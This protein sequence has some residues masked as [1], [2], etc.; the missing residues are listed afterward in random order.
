MREH[1]EKMQLYEEQNRVAIELLDT[2]ELGAVQ[3]FI[4]ASFESAAN[5]HRRKI[6]LP[7]CFAKQLGD[8]LA[9]YGIRLV[10]TTRFLAFTIPFKPDTNV[11]EV[12][13][14]LVAEIGN[15]AWGDILR[16][17]ANL[18]PA[19]SDNLLFFYY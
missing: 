6:I 5:G 16:Q 8:A 3:D 2:L 17:N 11:D 19:K 13:G 10:G 4:V 14:K 9:P 7:T 12:I 1:R 18:R 15:L